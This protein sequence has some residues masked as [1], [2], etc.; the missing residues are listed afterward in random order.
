MEDF[1][2]YGHSACQDIRRLRNWSSK[3]L[4]GDAKVRELTK[5]DLALASGGV[6]PVVLYA[7]YTA[8]GIAVGWALQTYLDSQSSETQ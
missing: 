8:A 1:G 5:E 6:A 3:Q 7:A 2:K 4:T